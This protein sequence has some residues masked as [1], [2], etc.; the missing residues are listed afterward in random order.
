MSNISRTSKPI[1]FIGAAGEMSR[2]AIE[3]FATASDALLVLADINTTPLEA[4][5]AN[6]PAGRATSRELDLFDRA[7]LLDIVKGAGLVVLGAGP[8]ERTSEPVLTACLEA[9]V[10]YLDFDDDLESTNAALDLHERAKKEG[11]PCYIGCG[12]SPGMTNVV[13]VDAANDLDTVDSLDVCWLVGD[14]R[15]GIGK[16]VLEHLMHIAAGQCLT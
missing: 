9:K 8:Y 14:E 5:V 1:I 15:P 10:P 7:A 12:A 4:L 3:R 16:A 6:L 11:V 13:A 2:V